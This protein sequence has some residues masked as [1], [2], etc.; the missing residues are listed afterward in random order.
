MHS[1]RPIITLLTDF[2]TRDAYVA[3]MKGVILGLNPEV[4]LVDLSHEVPS[5]DIL[6]GAFVLAEA[7][8]YFPPGTIHL[9]VVDPEVGTARRG[10]AARARGRYFVGPDNGLFHL[11]WQGAG[12]LEIV[13]LTNPAYFR[14]EVSATFHGRDVFAPVAAHLSLGV[15]LGEFGPA[16]H[17]PVPLPC[18]A[19]G[20]AREAARGEIIYV[21][22]FGNL[23]SN[24]KA[25]ALRDWLAGRPAHVRVGGLTLTG[26]ARTYG[27]VPPGQFLALEGSH[28]FLEV[29]VN[30]GSA[31]QGLKVAV[32]QPVEV[33]KL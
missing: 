33:V 2:G 20:F 10:L 9:A 11:A 22:R 1:S 18:P 28:G 30:Q 29:A 12:D 17:D 6:A 23:V 26:L 13:S 19:P 7:A 3:A 25:A 4:V 5:Q 21:D 32:G 14:P 16:I 31:A 27:E 15:A 24:L 8:P